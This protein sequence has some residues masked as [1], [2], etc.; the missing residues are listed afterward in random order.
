MLVLRLAFVP[1]FFY[2]ITDLFFQN[3]HLGQ[4]TLLRTIRFVYFFCSTSLLNCSSSIVIVVSS[5]EL[6]KILSSSLDL[7]AYLVV[8]PLL[9]TSLSTCLVISKLLPKYHLFYNFRSSKVSSFSL[10]FLTLYLF[11][12]HYQN[13]ILWILSLSSIAFVILSLSSIMIVTKQVILYACCH[14]HV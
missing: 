14:L 9:P 3:H 1:W 6:V 10:L 13:A 8:L 11:K 4:Q 12:A 5:V 7:M 2:I